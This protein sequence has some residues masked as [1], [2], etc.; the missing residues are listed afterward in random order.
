M[1]KPKAYLPTLYRR[2]FAR[3]LAQNDLYQDRIYGTDKKNLFSDVQGEVLEIGA[4]TGVNLPYMPE[5]VRWTGVEPDPNM[6][7]Y[8]Y[9]KASFLGR[10]ID[11]RSEWAES[12]SLPD[13]SID[14]V[15]CTLVLCSVRDPF[16]VL[17]EVLR[18]LKPGGALLFIEHVAA[19]EGTALHK[20]QRMVRPLWR[21]AAGGCQPDRKTGPLISEA[22]FSSVEI[23]HFY[24]PVP[25]MVRIINPHIMGRAVK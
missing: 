3:T 23:E 19:S 12:L 8:I 5:T 4:G 25:W 18:V 6:H 1:C 14:F 13:E 10:S 24:A 22:G 21:L 17:Q 11:I 2:V 9:E 7:R 15:I 20:I 16:R